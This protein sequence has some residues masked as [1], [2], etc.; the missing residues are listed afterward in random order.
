M[1]S[2][3]AVPDAADMDTMAAI[4]MQAMLRDTVQRVDD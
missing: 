3:R 1:S 4:A 2:A